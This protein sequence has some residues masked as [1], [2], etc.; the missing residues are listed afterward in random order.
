M[1]VKEK[2]K[3]EKKLIISIPLTEHKGKIRVK[4]RQSMFEY[5][6]PVVQETGTL[7]FLNKIILSGKSATT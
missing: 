3:D 4:R 6:I 5:G 1:S 2:K 7:D